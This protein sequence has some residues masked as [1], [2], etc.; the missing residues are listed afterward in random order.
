MNLINLSQL[1]TNLVQLTDSAEHSLAH[2]A[3]KWSLTLSCIHANNVLCCKKQ[4]VRDNSVSLL[5]PK[6]FAYSLLQLLYCSEGRGVCQANI[7]QIFY[8]STDTF[9]T[10]PLTVNCYSLKKLNSEFLI[11]QPSKV[12]LS[13]HMSQVA[14]QAGA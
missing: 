9:A 5:V 11:S 12:R 1:L 13:L 8:F 3:S 7:S 6:H 10:C 2:F 4:I 14:H